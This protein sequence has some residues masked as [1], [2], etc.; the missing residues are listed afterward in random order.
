MIKKITNFLAWVFILV[1]LLL[2]CLV[3]WSVFKDGKF[4]IG[5]LDWGYA[6]N[7]NKVSGILGFLFT[8]AG[9]FAIFIT[10]SKQQEQFDKAQR[11]VVTQQFETT[12]FNMLN[13]LFNIKNSIKGNVRDISFVGQEFLSAILKELKESYENHVT[14]LDDIQAVIQSI[15]NNKGP[16]KSETQMVKDDLNVLYLSFYNLYYPQ[17]GHYFRYLYNLIK[18]TVDNRGI[19]PYLD[20][21]KYIQ[22]IQA[23]LSNDELGLIFC[24]SLSDKALNSE[25]ENKIYTWIEEYSLLENIDEKS[26]LNRSLHYL[27]PKTDFKFLYRDERKLKSRRL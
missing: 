19:D 16:G 10:L 14:Q 22:L 26:L 24:N 9:T 3:I 18:F 7:L 4:K 27:Y 12:F 2:S 21:K 20:A 6:E 17:L 1:G 25:K 23:Q 5:V 8:G 15:S 11:Q 13:Q